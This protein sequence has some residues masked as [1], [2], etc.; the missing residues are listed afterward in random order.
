MKHGSISKTGRKKMKKPGRFRRSGVGWIRSTS[1]SRI[2][3]RT[4]AFAAALVVFVTAYAMVLPAITMTKPKCGIE[5]H[6]HTEECYRVEQKL[7]CEN[8]DEDHVHTEECYTSQKV[9]ECDKEVHTHSDECYDKEEEPTSPAKEAEPVG[10]AGD[11]TPPIRGSADLSAYKDFAAYLESVGGRIESLLYDSNNNLIDNMYEASGNGYTYIL[12]LYSPKIV[13]DTYFYYLPRGIDVDF[14]SKTG[15]ISNGSSTI[16]TY[17]ISDDSTYILFTFD[18]Q[19]SLYQNISGQIMLTVSFEEQISA[20]VSKTGWLIS[21]EGEM[22]GYFHFKISAKI[23]ADREGLAQREWKFEDRSEVTRQWFHDFGDPVNAA[24]T[25]V[26]ISY[27]NVTNYEI[28]NIK[29]VYRDSRVQIAYYVD[30]ETKELYLV[31]RCQCEDSRLC[32][33][34]KDD[35]CYCTLLKDYP[36][37]CTCWCLDENA[38][39][40]IVYKNAINGADGSYIL[41]DQNELA[42]VDSLSYE[43]KVTLTGSYRSSSGGIVTDIKKATAEIRYSNLMEKQEMVRASEGSGYQSEF[44]IT[45]NKEKADLSKLDVDGDGQYDKYVVIRDVMNN[46]KL[47][48]GS[49]RITAEDVHGSQFELVSGRDFTVDVRQTDTGADV[50]IR[51]N[52]LGRYTYYIDYN[53][54]VY[55]E[56]TDKTIEIS[57]DAYF[58]LYGN[59]EEDD[60]FSNPHY[61]YT[62]KF[63]YSEHWDYLKYEVRVLK[64]DYANHDIHLEGAVYGLYAADGTLM[65]ERT[66]DED[67]RCVFAT[68]AVEGLIFSTDTMYY[69]Q[70]IS[71]PPGYD[72]NVVPYWFYF[73]EKRDSAGEQKM[74]TDYPGVNITYVAPNDDKTF[75]I[76]ME[77]TDEKCFVLPATGSGGITIYLIAGTVLIT[78]SVVCI[79]IG[80]KLKRRV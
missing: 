9:L 10:A 57:N 73:S 2:L 68:N 76:E 40:D 61:R 30:D 59:R 21:P 65:A 79:I 13:P 8:T 52:K 43:N 25:N 18:E 55:S 50:Q 51:L 4:F 42:G 72:L 24:N 75:V 45:V 53:T 7:I 26:Y 69:I 3:K 36:G 14:A 29:D 67:G 80:R 44:R 38:T 74:E 66:T 12:R 48:T 1:L 33:E 54:Q 28:F 15:D 39:V 64:V 5:E 47:V 32:L 71:P 23:P 35:H 56:E 78:V 22:D 11:E 17:R 63:A 20:S 19:S 6:S 27:G 46:L 58:R 16:G 31:N 41:R 49:V 62:R 70:E 60:E 37:W 34:S 77:L